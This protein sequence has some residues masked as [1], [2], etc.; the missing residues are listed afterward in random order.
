MLG[1]S[2]WMCHPG[3][4]TSSLKQ[5]LIILSCRSSLMTWLCFEC[6]TFRSR[7]TPLAFTLYIPWG[8]RLV[9]FTRQRKIDFTSHKTAKQV[10]CALFCCCQCGICC[11]WVTFSKQKRKINMFLKLIFLSSPSSVSGWVRYSNNLTLSLELD[12][13]PPWLF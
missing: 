7:N 4:S 6:Q 2:D 13:T 9:Y 5:I 10:V 11:H 8:C 1:S 12:I 3:C